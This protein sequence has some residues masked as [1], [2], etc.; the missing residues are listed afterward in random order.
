AVEPTL[1]IAS[2][3]NPLIFL[4]Y[5]VGEFKK[6]SA[7]EGLEV[8]KIKPFCQHFGPS[9]WNSLLITNVDKPMVL[10]SYIPCTHSSI[11]QTK[12]SHREGHEASCVGLETMPLDQD[13]EG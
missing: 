3:T 5:D 4:L 2:P 12:L 13:I 6:V 10:V 7:T 8:C 9:A 1:A 11:L